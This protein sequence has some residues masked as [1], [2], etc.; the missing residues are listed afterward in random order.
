[1]LQVL[2][3]RAETLGSWQLIPFR[4]RHTQGAHGG[5]FGRETFRVQD[6]FS[7]P[8]V[9]GHDGTWAHGLGVDHVVVMP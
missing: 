3:S 4:V 2:C 8:S 1:M 7:Q 9:P 6:I 5:N